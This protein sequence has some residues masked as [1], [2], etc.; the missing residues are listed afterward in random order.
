MNPPHRYESKRMSVSQKG[1]AD[2]FWDARD[3]IHI[4]Y[5]L[6][7]KKNISKYYAILLDT[8]SDHL[9]KRR[10]RLAQKIVLFHQ[11]IPRVLTC[12]VIMA[13]SIE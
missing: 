6:K 12:V 7:R 1:L 2:S 5:F 11:E 3:I 9:K 8:L 4:D 13:K 10:P